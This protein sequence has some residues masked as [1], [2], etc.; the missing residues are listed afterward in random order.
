MNGNGVAYGQ[1]ELG[2]SANSG[3]NE[4]VP[5]YWEN[6][7]NLPAISGGQERRPAVFVKLHHDDA[8]RVSD[9]IS[10]RCPADVVDCTASAVAE[11]NWL[12]K[13]IAS[14]GPQCI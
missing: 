7:N 5:V 3:S 13:V 11:A 6:W 12:P 10:P 14:D 4:E 1:G 2:A 8:G 9:G